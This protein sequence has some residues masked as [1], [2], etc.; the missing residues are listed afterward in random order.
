MHITVTFKDGRIKDFK[1]TPRPG[2][3]YSNT[4]EFK[5]EFAVIKDEWDTIYAYPAAD[6]LEITAE[7]E[8]RY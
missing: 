3:S 8:R 1:R 6:I 2:G 7:P 5:G 4:L